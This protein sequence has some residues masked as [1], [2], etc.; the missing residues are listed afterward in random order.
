LSDRL[1]WAVPRHRW[2]AIRLK[3]CR[4]WMKCTHVKALRPLAVRLACW[5]TP[6]YKGR[7]VLARMC[8]RGYISPYATINDDIFRSGTQVFIGDN[9]VV[10]PL[11]P[12]AGPVEIGDRVHIHKDT[13][14]E[15]GE[16]GSIVIGDDTHI[17]VRC[18]FVAGGSPIKIG[19]QVQIAPYCAFFSYDHDIS[20]G[21]PLF[22]QPLRTKGGIVIEDDVWLGVRVVVLDGVRI[23]RGAV[24]SA[25]AVVTADV[26]AGA[27]V[28]GVPARLIK[29]RD[30]PGPRVD[31]KRAD[32]KRADGS[33]GDKARLASSIARRHRGGNAKAG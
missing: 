33:V 1:T 31:D 21:K 4:F 20:P 27:V 11:D 2:N 25:G 9:V 28:G 19:R 16:G 26:P 8:R 30:N 3:W 17:Q 15:T 22:A 29:M 24:V 10:F 5:G 32:A 18:H 6:P 13:I 12:E 14:M 7:H 23:G